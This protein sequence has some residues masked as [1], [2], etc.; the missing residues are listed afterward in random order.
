MNDAI[1]NLTSR[2]FINYYG[3]Q[4]FGAFTSGTHIVG[5]SMLQGDYE[6]AC[7][8]ILE[9]H[10]SALAAAQ[11]DSPDT[12]VSRDD[13]ARASALN[14]FATT[15]RSHPAIEELPRKFSAEACLVRHLSRADLHNDY[16]GALQAINRNLRLMYVHAYQSLVWNT[17]ASA[18]WKQ[19]GNRVLP[20]DLV[21][22]DEHPDPASK[23][24]SNIDTAEIVDQD[25]EPILAADPSDRATTADDIFTRA[26]AVTEAE[27]KSP[28]PES[29][30]PITIFDI[31]LPTPGYDILYPANDTADIYKEFM[32]SERGGGLDP[33]DM[34]RKWKDV[35]LSGS[36]R[37]LLA[38]PVGRV[39]WEIRAYGA[40]GD[41][42][43]FVET[44]LDKIE[45]GKT[46]EKSGG[47]GERATATAKPENGSGNGKMDER[48]A[49][50]TK[51]EEIAVGNGAPQP[52]EPAVQPD[53]TAATAPTTTP[54]EETKKPKN[55]KLALILKLQLGSSTYAT[56]ALRE[57][58]KEG[59]V[60]TWKAEYA[61]GR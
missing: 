51:D 50:P 10:P 30:K 29:G 49:E 15:G 56:M 34:R 46:V 61:G 27:L 3:L 4:R 32:A 57:L 54:T 2:G 59:G 26:R 5:R 25:G 41:D 11:S 40:N 6:T 8:T 31:V 33:H 9:V 42:E 17:A 36:Y 39:E 52:P 14:S 48:T 23:Q 22:V 44:D 24:D 12:D 19:H 37:K 35:S 28:P 58:M 20:G 1:E 21:L 38:K 53:M 7:E 18:R 13:I 16:Q 55:D 60:Q 43:Q 47:N 45:K